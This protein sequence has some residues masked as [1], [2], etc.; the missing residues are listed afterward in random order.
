MIAPFFSHSELLTGGQHFLQVQ[1]HF[2]LPPLFFFDLAVVY[3]IMKLFYAC[4]L[5]KFLTTN[6]SFFLFWESFFFSSFVFF[7]IEE[8]LI[9]LQIRGVEWRVCRG[10]GHAIWHTTGEVWWKASAW[11]SALNPLCV[12]TGK[13]F[14]IGCQVL[15]SGKLVSNNGL[16]SFT[17]RPVHNLILISVLWFLVNLLLYCFLVTFFLQY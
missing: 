6:L 12:I 7:N 11:W 10:S 16:T 1:F 13:Y 5:K 2:R 17:R 3:L 9:G 4:A 15:K 8:Q 14:Y